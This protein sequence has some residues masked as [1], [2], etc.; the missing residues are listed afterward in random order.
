MKLI[1]KCNDPFISE[2]VL[3]EAKELFKENKE[4]IFGLLKD[5]LGEDFKEK[6]VVV[7]LLS[8]VGSMVYGHTTETEEKVEVWIEVPEGEP[9]HAV[10]IL[11]WELVFAL[12]KK[13]AY[14]IIFDKFKDYTLAEILS[15]QIGVLVEKEVISKIGPKGYY[16][17]TILDHSSPRSPALYKIQKALIE[18]WPDLKKFK[19]LSEW[20]SGILKDFPSEVDI[21]EINMAYMM[22]KQS[23]ILNALNSVLRELRAIRRRGEARERHREVGDINQK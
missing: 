1:L 6:E 21:S 8:H 18:K 11:G 7:N 20:L 19:S 12:A 16:P 5:V 23:Q 4:M 14:Q 10:N 13:K 9:K 22:R 17:S 3:A 2:E 15:D